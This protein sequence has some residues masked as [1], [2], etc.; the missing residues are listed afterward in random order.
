MQHDEMQSLEHIV[1]TMREKLPPTIPQY[2]EF[3]IFTAYWGAPLGV[4]TSGHAIDDILSGRDP[5]TPL[6]AFF[7]VGVGFALRALSDEPSD[8]HSRFRGE[9]TMPYH[10]YQAIPLPVRAKARARHVGE[11]VLC[12]VGSSAA[13][14]V[15]LFALAGIVKSAEYLITLATR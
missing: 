8:P 12:Y 3:T 13:L 11:E 4:W 6:A 5:M 1:D 10:I 2:G 15:G 14:T 7:L 9:K